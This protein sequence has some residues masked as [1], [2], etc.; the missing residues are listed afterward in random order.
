MKFNY[1]PAAY[2]GQLWIQG[3]CSHACTHCA[4]QRRT[5]CAMHSSAIPFNNM[6]TMPCN[7]TLRYNMQC[8]ATSCHTTPFIA[9]QR[10]AIQYHTMQRRPCYV[11]SCHGILCH[12][13]PYNAMSCN[14][15]K[16]HA[17][18]CH[19]TSCYAMPYQSTTCN[20]MLRHATPYNTITYHATPCH[21]IIN[22]MPG[23][24]TPYNTMQCHATPYH[25]THCNATILP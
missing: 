19:A 18:P 23:H 16:R 17:A 1:S 20:T 21:A 12:L 13:T 5:T 8:N 11:M 2:T 14:A 6:P 3:N 15:V 10:L 7:T 4:M 25:T 9:L 24:A 22:A